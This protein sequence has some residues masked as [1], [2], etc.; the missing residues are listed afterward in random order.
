MCK[1][2]YDAQSEHMVKFV[3]NGICLRYMQCPVSDCVHRITP[4]NL[5]EEVTKYLSTASVEFLRRIRVRR[6][7][8]PTLHFIIDDQI[9]FTD[10][11]NEALVLLQHQIR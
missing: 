9:G 11:F 4:D 8:E 6:E 7:L 1:C 2:K 10:N 5:I 3:E